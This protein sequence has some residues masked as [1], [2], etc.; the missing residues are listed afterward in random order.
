MLRTEVRKLLFD[1][2][3]AGELIRNSHRISQEECLRYGKTAKCSARSE[4][5]GLRSRAA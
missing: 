1:I 4:A 3:H 5:G 2:A